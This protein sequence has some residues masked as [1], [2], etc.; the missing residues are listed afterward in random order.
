MS[1]TPQEPGH[2]ARETPEHWRALVAQVGR[3]VA[4]PLSAALERVVQLAT[5]GRIDQASLR[6]LRGE[7]ESA[8]RIGIV[9][10]QLARFGARRLRQS[11]EKLDL[12]A[13]LQNVLTQRSRELGSR[14][15]EVKHSSRPIE[16]LADPALLFSL[17]NS[18]V[19]WAVE[20]GGKRVTLRV[21]RDPVTRHGR[22]ACH[23][24]EADARRP[25]VPEAAGMQRPVS[26]N[27]HL[28][29][30]LAGSLGLAVASEHEAGRTA[31]LLG[32]PKTADLD[33]PP[34]A[35][36]PERDPGDISSL[37]SKPLAGSHVLVLSARRALR[38]EV[39]ESIARMGLVLDFVGSV[40]EA[41]SF[42]NETMPHAL[43]YEGVLH[44]AKLE[45]FARELRAE[46]PAIGLVEI[47]EQ[48]DTWSPPLTA[49]EPPALERAKVGRESLYHQLPPALVFELSRQL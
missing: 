26:L 28:L 1:D 38:L 33:A 11:D 6:E 37:N 49:A 30:E 34:D 9:G 25:A 16:V 39:R 14:G 46:L 7:I 10:Q 36:P 31:L 17:L 45:Q 2:D 4:E 12:A 3:E 13:T 27:R 43:V 32:F 47:V 21:D 18:L 41:I 8:R 48:A 42:C 23:V 44:G 24:H 29:L 22:I 15:I 40:D 35:A 5:T 20:L 19:D